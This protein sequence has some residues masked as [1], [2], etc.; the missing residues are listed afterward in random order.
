MSEVE[1]V[2]EAVKIALNHL[3][4]KGI[5]VSVREVRSVFRDSI[6]WSV[7]VYSDIFTGAIVIKAK[8]GEI[9]TEVVL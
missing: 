6:I 5:V 9:A 2:L 4:K 3:A 7:E 1:D 8:T